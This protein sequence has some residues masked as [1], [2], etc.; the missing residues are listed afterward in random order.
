[1]KDLLTQSR[2]LFALDINTGETLWVYEARA[3]VRHNAIAIS[4]GRVFLVDR[5]KEII[6]LPAPSAEEVPTRLPAQPPRTS[7]LLCLDATT[8]KV[9]WEQG[10]DIYGTML[11]VSATHRVLLMTV[12]AARCAEEVWGKKEPVA[13]A[14]AS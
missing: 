6:D 5:S 9:L 3:S 13:G 8:G 10:E 4:H 11:A 7:S 1:M 2:S 14:Q 12:D